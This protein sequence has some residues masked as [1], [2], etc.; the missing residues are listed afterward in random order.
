[1]EKCDPTVRL[2][3]RLQGKP[4]PIDLGD[5]PLLFYSTHGNKKKHTTSK[6]NVEMSTGKLLGPISSE[7]A[8]FSNFKSSGATDIFR[9]TW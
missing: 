7:M 1:V 4:K 6:K 8:D 2:G 3:F 9:L 5:Y